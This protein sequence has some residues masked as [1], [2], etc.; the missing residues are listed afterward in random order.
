MRPRAISAKHGE[1]WFASEKEDEEE[2]EDDEEED[3]AA[4][5][6]T[7]LADDGSKGRRSWNAERW[8]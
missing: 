8:T 4:G 1:A 6:W 5:G 2:E 7:S 3:E